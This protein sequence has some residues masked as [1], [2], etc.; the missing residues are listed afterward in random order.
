MAECERREG[1]D[2]GRS[3]GGIVQHDSER[4]CLSVS[5]SVPQDAQLPHF[6]SPKYFP[7]QSYHCK[8]EHSVMSSTCN[9][10]FSKHPVVVLEH[11]GYCSLVQAVQKYVES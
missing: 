2:R 4:L 3:G 10:K 7:F 6:T 5:L 9:L 11:C 1:G 8:S